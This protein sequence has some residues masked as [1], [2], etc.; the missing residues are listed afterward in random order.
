MPPRKVTCLPNFSLIAGIFGSGKRL[1]R[2]ESH[3]RQAEYVR[4]SRLVI[5]PSLWSITLVFGFML[6]HHF[7]QSLK[8]RLDEFAKHREVK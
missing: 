6:F 4:T 5:A 7:D 3:P 2:M 1:E 8:A